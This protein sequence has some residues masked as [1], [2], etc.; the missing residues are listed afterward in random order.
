MQASYAGNKQ[1]LQ[2]GSREQLGGAAGPSSCV[3]MGRLLMLA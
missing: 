1:W 2:V 3:V